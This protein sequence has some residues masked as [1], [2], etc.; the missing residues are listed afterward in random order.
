MK[1]SIK[2]HYGKVSIVALITLESA[3]VRKAFEKLFD[4]VLVFLFLGTLVFKQTLVSSRYTV[5]FITLK[6]GKYYLMLNRR[7]VCAPAYVTAF[8]PFLKYKHP[9]RQKPR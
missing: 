2:Q 6:N 1:I 7:C 8:L 4:H 3:S 5:G 9:E